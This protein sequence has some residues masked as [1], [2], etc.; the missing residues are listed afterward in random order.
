MEP[1]KREFGKKRS[2]Q[3]RRRSSFVHNPQN[4]FFDLRE[5]EREEKL[6]NGAGR[7]HDRR[8]C[9]DSCIREL[10]FSRILYIITYLGKYRVK[11]CKLLFYCD[12]WPLKSLLAEDHA[13]VG[14]TYV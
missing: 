9:I 12:M 3:R 6:N 13:H 1:E 5:R 11:K 8:N 14:S 7:M 2:W 10:R 4:T